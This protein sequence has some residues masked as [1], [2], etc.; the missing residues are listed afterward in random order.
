MGR[1]TIGLGL[2]ALVGCVGPSTQSQAS[3][4]SQGLVLDGGSP[5]CPSNATTCVPISAPIEIDGGCTDARWVVLRRSETPACPGIAGGAGGVWESSQLFPASPQLPP[6]L[7]PFCLYEWKS[8]LNTPPNVAALNGLDAG[9]IRRDRDCAVVAGSGSL[10]VNEGWTEL[11]QDFF[12]QTGRTAAGGNPAG[13]RIAV[14]DSAPR[15]VNLSLDR[16]GHGYAVAQM[17]EE[18]A[19]VGVGG[20]GCAHVVSS[21][22]ALPRLALNRVDL[23]HGGY[24]GFQSELAVA[25]YQSVYDWRL[26]PGPDSRLVVNVSLGWEA[27]YGGEYAFADELAASVRAVH[28]AIEHASCWGA[29]IVVAAGNDSGGPDPA[30]GPLYP[31]AWERKPRPTA[32]RCL[33]LEGLGYANG[34][35]LPIQPPAGT[36]APLVHAVGGVQ[37]NDVPLT[38]ARV[39]GRPR[40][41][42]PG[43]HGVAMSNDGG[44]TSMMT[45]SSVS[46]AV[47]SGAVASAWGLR[48]TLTAPELMQQVHLSSVGL[49][50]QADF[51]LNDACGTPA[52]AVRRLNQCTL[53][54]RVC[55]SGGP[56]C[57]A[58]APVC[59]ARPAGSGPLPTLTQ[60][61]RD[62]IEASAT[63]KVDAGSLGFE[64]PPLPV[65]GRE[66][67]VSA[68]AGY[69]KSTCP[70]RQYDAPGKRPW[71][72]PQPPTDPCPLCYLTPE[73]GT[74]RLTL[75][76]D[77]RFEGTLL[78]TPVLTVNQKI[79]I[80]LPDME[81]LRGGDIVV[82]EPVE[83]GTS[84]VEEATVSFLVLFDG[85]EYS[86][87]SALLISDPLR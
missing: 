43:S 86:M 68:I 54:R 11:R 50:G 51:C 42:A 28:T 23:V 39:G 24:F 71:S 31:A 74:G 41:V 87:T 37:P 57:P 63:M 76:I 66:R 46:A 29:A 20:G 5:A 8:T 21:H 10:A 17:I 3:W 78:R 26:A 34:Y 30:V 67:I 82:I 61:Q 80:P 58:V 25:L 33:Q 7:A 65:C 69:R 47:V 44:P 14:V 49:T 53:L 4:V 48:P 6:G 35:A 40:L 13:V 52:T 64:L 9:S 77:E 72:G 59:T 32:L 81:T 12:E 19:C 36:Y 75:N 45:G 16:S 22:L 1:L 18:L 83:L 55:A 79:L 85:V 38:N 60:A 73:K 2:L 62:S 27:M 56:R 84:D 70:D 15:S